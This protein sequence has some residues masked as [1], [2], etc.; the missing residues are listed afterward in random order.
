M[1]TQ[2]IHLLTPSSRQNKSNIGTANKTSTHQELSQIGKSV[3][4]HKHS[5]AYIESLSFFCTESDIIHVCISLRWMRI[6]MVSLQGAKGGVTQLSSSSFSNFKM[7]EITFTCYLSN[8]N[9]T[10]VTAAKV[11]VTPVKYEW[12]LKILTDTVSKLK[13]SQMKKLTKRT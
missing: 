2:N 11:Q 6:I 9:L 13:L 3:K 1:N 7:I 8:S 4:F 5:L 12:D 10:G